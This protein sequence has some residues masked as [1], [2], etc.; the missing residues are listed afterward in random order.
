MTGQAAQMDCG[1][2]RVLTKDGGEWTPE[3][4][5]EQCAE[6]LINISDAADPALREQARYF[7]ANVVKL[8][9]GYI[10]KG[11]EIEGR[12]IMKDIR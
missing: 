3:E 2:V 8:V 1:S 9:A 12:R 11:Q 4:L 5:A 6:Q 7:R 10:R